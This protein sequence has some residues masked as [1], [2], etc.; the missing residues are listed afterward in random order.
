MTTKTT[1]TAAERQGTAVKNFR[2]IVASRR[3]RAPR[4]SV[5]MEDR[6]TDQVLA[7]WDGR[8]GPGDEVLRV[9]PDLAGRW[10]V[11]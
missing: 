4:S 10:D 1:Q 6:L 2:M 3:V 5:V 9:S 7:R 8:S 11:E